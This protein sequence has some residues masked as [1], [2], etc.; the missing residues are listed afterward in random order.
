MFVSVQ[1]DRVG[2]GH[3]YFLRA[4]VVFATPT[5]LGQLTYG[6]VALAAVVGNENGAHHIVAALSQCLND[7]GFTIPAGG[8]TYWNGE[9]L[10]RTD[11][12]YLGETPESVESTM[13]TMVANAAHL[14]SFLAVQQYP[15]LAS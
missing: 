8:A 6:K 11:C 14:A 1:L 4:N 2:A 10:H 13:T 7:V 15:A 9:A 5:W 3:V 12:N